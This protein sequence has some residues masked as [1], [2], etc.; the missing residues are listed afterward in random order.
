MNDV[1]RHGFVGALKYCG[2]VH[3]IPETANT[4]L[5][6]VFVEC[7]PP[8]ADLGAREIGEHGISWPHLSYIKRAIRILDKVVAFDS[9]IVGL[10]SRQ[11]CQMQIRNG[12]HFESLAL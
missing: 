8:F 4:H 7:A 11:L 3:V 9:F 2:L 12:D 5:D 10:V 6:E 1:E